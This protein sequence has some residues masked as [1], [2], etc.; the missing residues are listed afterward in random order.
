MQAVRFEC[1]LFEPFAS[2]QNGL[3]LPEADICR[4]DVVDALVDALMI[5]VFDRGFGLVL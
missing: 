2:L 4:C 3:V 1:P 5:V